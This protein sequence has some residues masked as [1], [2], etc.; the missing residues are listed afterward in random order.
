MEKIL[1]KMSPEDAGLANLWGMTALHRAASSGNFEAAKL[2]VNKNPN[3][4]NILDKYGDPPLTY[5]AS[6]GSRECVVYLWEV[7][8]E[9]VK[10]KDDVATKLLHDLTK[11]EHYGNY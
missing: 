10:L 4:P 9:D 5:A 11:G 1:K 8:K 6:T 2:L 7:T 3:L